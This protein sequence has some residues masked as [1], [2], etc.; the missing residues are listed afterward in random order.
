MATAIENLKAYLVTAAGQIRNDLDKL[1]CLALIDSWYPA[2]VAI[3]A[4]RAN[5]IS[6]YSLN[7]RSVT[8]NSI[9]V[10]ESAEYR[11]MAQIKDYLYLRGVTLVD[12]RGY[13]TATWP[14]AGGSV[15]S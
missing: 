11:M 7:G 14:V 4:L 13:Y 5:T 10:L 9:G 2:R 15:A 1:E 3:D 12:N 6:S 8:R